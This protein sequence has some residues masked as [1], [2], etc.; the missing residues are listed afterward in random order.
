MGTDI[1]FGRDEDASVDPNDGLRTGRGPSINTCGIQAL[2]PSQL[3][4]ISVD[5]WWTAEIC[6]NFTS[7][8]HPIPILF[9][10]IQ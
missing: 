5:G 6:A 4:D 3:S 7:H 10:L 9:V 1:N 2:L 8:K